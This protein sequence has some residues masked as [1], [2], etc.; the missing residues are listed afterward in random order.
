MLFPFFDN[1][2]VALFN[3]FAN[4]W[5]LVTTATKL[6]FIF[7]R[8]NIYTIKLLIS[9]IETRST[10]V[11]IPKFDYDIGVNSSIYLN[12]ICIFTNY[13]KSIKLT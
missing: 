13:M 3:Q 10:M 1:V 9:S 4:T 8:K 6:T 7:V 2:Q 12:K 11:N 5:L